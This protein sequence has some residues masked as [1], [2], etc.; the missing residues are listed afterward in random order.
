MELQTAEAALQSEGAG[1]LG[2]RSV[3][4]LFIQM[5]GEKQVRLGDEGRQA[6][7]QA[8]AGSSALLHMA[9]TVLL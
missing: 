4:T 5:T 3:Q 9:L 2:N 7:R 8:G 1:G 6:G